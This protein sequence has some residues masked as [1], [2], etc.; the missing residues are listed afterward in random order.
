VRV[1]LT[2]FSV[3][4]QCRRL[5]ELLH[6]D[7][8]GVASETEGRPRVTWWAAPGAP[9]LPARLDDVLDGRAPGWIVRSVAGRASVFARS[10]AETPPSAAAVL[11]SLGPSL[12]EAALAEASPPGRGEVGAEP[13]LDN[14]PGLDEVRGRPG[15]EPAA[16]RWTGIR[17]VIG[18]LAGV[19]CDTVS[20]FAPSGEGDWR[21]VE[22]VGPERPWH[23]VLDPGTLGADAEGTGSDDVTAIPGVGPRLAA[24]GCGSLAMAPLPGGGRLILD[25]ARRG[26]EARW[27]RS[28]APFL[29]LLRAVVRE[30]GS[31]G[32]APEDPGLLGRAVASCRRILESPGATPRALLEAVAVALGATEAFYLAERRGD[33]AVIAASPGTWPR[34]V[35]A[36]VRTGLASLPRNEPIDDAR[37]RQLGVLLGASGPVVGAAFAGSGDPVE[38]LVASWP[39]GPAPP[40][41]LLGAAAQMVGGTIAAIESRGRAVEEQMHRVREQWAYEIH[42]GLTQA[43]TT[44]VLELEAITKRI[45]EDPRQAIE[46]LER[47]R[48][49]IRR[50]LQDLRGW[51]FTLSQ[52]RPREPVGDQPLVRYVEDVARRWRLPADLQVRGTIDD[53]PRSLLGTAYVVI[54]EA[55]TNAAKHAG[56]ASV[57]VRV[58]RASDAL[59][60]EVRDAGRGF[61]PRTARAARAGGHLGLSM[62]ERRVAE[63]GGTLEVR[64]VPG[65]GTRVVARLPLPA[66][67]RP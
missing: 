52:D 17:E 15:T 42:D 14:E 12:V 67:G 41:L 11:E 51:L 4:E 7:A 43:V 19:G 26:D 47:S 53:L 10:T 49:E 65:R 32:A 44:A 33:L 27:V 5:G 48:E 64:S 6:L 3:T 8:V 63:A 23:A 58:D 37:L 21:L 55:L 54:R 2:E 20:M 35:P 25:S 22:R 38:L 40:A 24:L 46:M 45:E 60:V 36:E 66:G 18:D 59:V 28:A 29:S 56:A 50:S 57:K 13:G 31:P 16:S 61:S 39:N 9:A 34:R 62:M 30:A 1:T